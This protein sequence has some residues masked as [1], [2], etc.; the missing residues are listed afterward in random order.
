[1]GH[2][3]DD[4]TLMTAD[5]LRAFIGYAE[6]D[7]GNGQHYA[8]IQ[9][10]N[11]GFV[12]HNPG[13]PELEVMQTQFARDI[14]DSANREIAHDGAWLIVFTHPGVLPHLLATQSEYARFNV[15]WMDKDGDIQFRLEWSIG[16]SEDELTFSDVLL[17][18]KESW[19]ERL[20]MAYQQWHLLNVQVL[21]AKESQTFKKAK[22]Q[23]PSGRPH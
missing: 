20:E 13:S 1:M 21:A 12:D 19:L 6:E 16:E 2:K 23:K 7:G 18:G 15:V 3:L 17:S 8:V 4:D 22:G 9:R 5:L 11:G 14:V 10:D